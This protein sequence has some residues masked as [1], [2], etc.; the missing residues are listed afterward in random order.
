MRDC[1]ND[2]DGRTTACKTARSNF[3]IWGQR[4]SSGAVVKGPRWLGYATFH[5][6]A[7]A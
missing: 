2:D 7:E 1:N 3:G 4:A 5:M 6:G